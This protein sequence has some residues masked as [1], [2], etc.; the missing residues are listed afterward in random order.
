MRTGLIKIG[1]LERANAVLTT[2]HHAGF[3]DS[4]T[5]QL[6][7]VLKKFNDIVNDV[8]DAR[9]VHASRKLKLQ[10]QVIPDAVWIDDAIEAAEKCQAATE[11]ILS[12]PLGFV[13]SET[14]SDQRKSMKPSEKRNAEQ[15]AQAIA[16]S[17]VKT[18]VADGFQTLLHV[19]QLGSLLILTSPRITV[20]TTS[21]VRHNSG[22]DIVLQTEGGDS[23]EITRSGGDYLAES[24]SNFVV[25]DR[26][27]N[28]HLLS[29]G[30]TIHVGKR[31]RLKF[32]QS[33][34]ASDSAVLKISGSKM[35]QR[36]IRSIVL[37][38]ESLVFGASSGHFRV[39]GLRHRV[40]LSPQA[41]SGS[42]LIHQ[43]GSTDRFE[44]TPAATAT[45][46]GCRFTSQRS[47]T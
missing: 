36:Q 27:S 31:G 17:E 30:D 20:G 2:M 10:K 6:G 46:D 25:N 41:A 47:V 45:F 7:N 44:L 15:N 12:G 38:G 29:N 33:V 42:F 26:S 24:R 5:I 19:D 9:Y 18:P 32:L 16:N 3:E 8:R 22:S 37:L 14:G 13:V 21:S 28:Q 40:I 39:P 34:A 35:K 23:I 1:R 11:Q 4:Q 43:Q